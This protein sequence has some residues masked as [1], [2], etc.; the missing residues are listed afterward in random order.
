M[1]EEKTM[2]TCAICGKSYE[3]IEDRVDCESKCIVTR[4]KLEEENKR[5]KLEVKKYASEQEIHDALGSLNE[6]ISQHIKEYGSFMLTKNYPY[7]NY[8]FKNTAWWF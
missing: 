2:Y 3:L 4:K 5:K 1:T 6:K 7:L 8:I